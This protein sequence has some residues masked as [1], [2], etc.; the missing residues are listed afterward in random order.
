MG[1]DFKRDVSEE[2]AVTHWYDTVYLPIVTTV[3]ENNLLAEFAGKTET[4][5]YL[6]IIDYLDQWRTEGQSV[7]FDQAAA[8]FARDYA[9]EFEQHPLRNI[10]RGLQALFGLALNDEEAARSQSPEMDDENSTAN[11]E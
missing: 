9:G 4:D 3:R 11:S 5:L 1:L 2:E 10:V 7:T 8:E 6:S